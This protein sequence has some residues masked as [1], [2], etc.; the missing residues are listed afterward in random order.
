MR[1]LRVESIS[2]PVLYH[3]QKIVRNNA[4]QR[5]L[6]PLSPTNRF[7][8][9]PPRITNDFGVAFRSFRR[10]PQHLVERFYNDYTRVTGTYIERTSAVFNSF[11]II[12][13]IRQRM[14]GH[15]VHYKTPKPRESRG[16]ILRMT[17]S[18]Q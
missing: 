16:I 6:Q 7:L 13:E 10:A 2:L 5:R 18:S 3:P 8:F 12:G 11:R 4:F 14:P 1:F 15:D 17:I 9:D